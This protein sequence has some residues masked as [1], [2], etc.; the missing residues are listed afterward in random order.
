MVIELV[1]VDF[2]SGMNN[3]ISQCFAIETANMY[4][5]RAYVTS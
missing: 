1:E 2:S 5:D 3:T 4:L